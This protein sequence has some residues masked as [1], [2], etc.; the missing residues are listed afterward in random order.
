MSPA[1]NS[2]IRAVKKHEVRGEG[3]QSVARRALSLDEF[4]LVMRI[5]ERFPNM[6]ELSVRLPT[7]MK[8]QVHLIARIDDTAHVKFSD[9]HVH[10]QFEFALTVRLRWTNNCLEERDAPDQIILGAMNSDYCLIVA[11]SII[12]NMFSN[13]LMLPNRNTCF[14][15]PETILFL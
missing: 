13:L 1:V 3:V 5:C 4:C 6:Y 2:L 9:I 10:A 14:A 11:L 12:F 8:F 7:M 15:T